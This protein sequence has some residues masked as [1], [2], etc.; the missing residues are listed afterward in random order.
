[1]YLRSIYHP[2]LSILKVYQVLWLAPVLQAG[3]FTKLQDLQPR[4]LFKSCACPVNATRHQLMRPAGKG[5]LAR[6]QKGTHLNLFLPNVSQTS[7]TQ[8]G[9]LSCYIVK[10]APVL[11]SMCVV[12]TRHHYDV[13][14]GCA[15]CCIIQPTQ[16]TKRR[17]THSLAHLLPNKHQS[18]RDQPPCYSSHVRSS[19]SC[20]LR[21]SASTRTSARRRSLRRNMA[22]LSRS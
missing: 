9:A 5:K 7:S 22:P 16:R 15:Q 8:R 3:G 4:H 1:M 19:Q 18:P 6:V 21:I 12:T 11:H 14:Q 13:I 10:H 17:K 20:L 2:P